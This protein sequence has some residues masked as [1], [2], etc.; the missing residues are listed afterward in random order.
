M[1]K[2]LQKTDPGPGR[3]L[4]NKESFFS[5]HIIDN[6]RSMV[7]IINRDYVYEKVNRPFCA[8]HRGAFKSYVGK[9]LS[10]IWGT[11]T[12]RNKIKNKVDLCFAGKTIR[13]EASF[14][15]AKSGN[16]YFQVVFRPLKESG[17]RVSHVM[18][19]T[20]DVTDLKQSKKAAADLEKEFRQK[21]TE[22]EARLEQSRRL[23]TI[24]VLAG[25]IAH[26]FNN[27]L[28]TISGYTE[29]LQED[30]QKEPALAERTGRILSAVRR[31]QSLTNQILTFSR[32]EP[33][34][35][36]PVDVNEILKETVG[37]VR[38]FAPA[39]IIIEA[40]LSEIRIPVLADP[41][42]L[43]RIFL[44]L[45][46][47]AIQSMEQKPGTLSVNTLIEDGTL[48]KSGKIG[49]NLSEEYVV[50]TFRDNGTGMDQYLMSRIFEPFFTTKEV[51]KGIGLGLPVVYGIVTGMEGEIKVSSRV[52]EGSVFEVYLP[53]WRDL[54]A[55]PGADL[56]YRDQ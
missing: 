10:D 45:M 33:K 4:K 29:M 37:Y 22:F 34:E 24:G 47:N 51:G 16:R 41:T 40:D 32:Q 35:R 27:I 53:V 9:S 28:A 3:K 46:T 39:K 44:N 26:D 17:G 19:E 20:F 8:A 38:S 7:S 50:I 1:K 36:M 11:E 31:A 2:N 5:E 25:G 12:F 13:Y 15:T 21:E 14:K 55:D 56:N 54:P 49:E 43:F 18:A 52:N 42:D 30:L 6:S 23:E 48:A